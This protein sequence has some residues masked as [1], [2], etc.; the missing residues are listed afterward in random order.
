[1]KK[2]IIIILS[3]IL[4]ITNLNGCIF[5]KEE[6]EKEREAIKLGEESVGPYLKE[7][8]GM[9][10]VKI[11][12]VRAG[13]GYS[14]DIPVGYTGDAYVTCEF[15]GR[16]FEVLIAKYRNSGDNYQY[17]DI[18]S[19][20]EEHLISLNKYIKYVNNTRIGGEY[21]NYFGLE[22]Y[23]NGD[24]EEFLKNLKY[25]YADIYI[26]T[27]ND[28]MIIQESSKEFIDFVG[29]RTEYDST[30][31][32]RRNMNVYFFDYTEETAPELD[33]LQKEA[34]NFNNGIYPKNLLTYIFFESGHEP[35]IKYCHDSIDQAEL[36]TQE[37]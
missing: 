27:D 35:K 24:L 14:F 10:D 11:I 7:K 23:F 31:Y 34:D 25:I 29:E 20:V 4:L 16:E 5:S 37:K 3:I 1:M 2:K 9:E 26:L 6:Q 17:P 32:Y 18:I 13:V 30:N 12:D 19:A 8:Y 21:S 28:I 15:E 33:R 22:E 36:F